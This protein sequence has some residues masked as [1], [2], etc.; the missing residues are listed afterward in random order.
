[1]DLLQNCLRDKTFQQSPLRAFVR[2]NL[3][4][5]DT[6]ERN[7]KLSRE[8]KLPTLQT[9]LQGMGGKIHERNLDSYITNLGIALKDLEGKRILLIFSNSA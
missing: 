7:Y 4:R 8:V 5:F 1:M 6:P 3:L 2:N 9:E